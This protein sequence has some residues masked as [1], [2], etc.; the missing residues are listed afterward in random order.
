M[1]VF[2]QSVNFNADK[3]LVNFVEEKLQALEK[4]HDRIV[5]AEVFMKVQKTSEKENKIT[6]IKMN[7]PGNDL[8]VK[9]QSKTFEEGAVL[10]VD[11]L[12]RQLVKIKEK[13]RAHHA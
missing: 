2:V 12:K 9:K 3:D 13:Q 8:I 5:D 7:L 6:E 4:F 11:S 10:C 1:K